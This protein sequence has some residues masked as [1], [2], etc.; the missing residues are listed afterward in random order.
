MRRMRILAFMLAL[1]LALPYGLMGAGGSVNVA[2]A[3]GSRFYY[4]Q[5]GEDAK[6]F[7]DAMYEMYAQGIFK[8]GTQ[9]YDLVE[10]GHITSEQLAVYEGRQDELLRLFGAARDAFY[11]DYPDI[12]YVDFS[13]LSITVSTSGESE[14]EDD[15]AV[16]KVSLG[17]GRSDTY[18]VQGF[19]DEQQVEHAIKEQA[20][21]IDEIVQ[22]A[23]NQASSVRDQ[24]I[25]VHNAI[26]DHTEYRL[27]T[28]CDAGNAGHVRTSYGALVRG[29]SLCEGYARAVKT[30]LDAMGINSVLVQG[31]YRAPDG[32]D[33][34][35]MWNYVQIDG[36]WYGLDAT[37]SDGM[38]GTVDS[39]KYLLA[40]RAVMGE[41]HKPDG[42]MSGSGFRFTYPELAEADKD[43]GD[44]G[45]DPDEG[46]TDSS[47]YKTLFDK[48]G[49]LVQYRD[50]TETEGDV[51]VFKVSYKG[52][53]Y[54]EAVDTEGVYILSRF[55]QYQPGTGDYEVGNWGYSDPK[56][57]AMPQLADA[58]V[59]ANGNSR[60]IEFAITR[61]AP[62]GPLYGDN[63][64]AED[65]EKNWKFQGTEE[66]FIVST[67]KLDNLKGTFI[68]SPFAKKVT[69]SNTGYLS[70]GKKYHITAVFNE[71]LVLID[72]ESVGC[73]MSVKDGWTA[74]E[75][76]KIENFKWD[77][78]R[79][80]EFDFTPSDQLADNY[81]YYTFQVTGLQGIGSLK[82][83]D[84]FQYE[85]KKKISICAYRSQG[86]YLNLGAKP[87]LLEPTDIFCGDWVN[88]NGERL[89]DVKN[90]VLT[91]SKPELVVETPD[92]GQNK[93]M[94]DMIEDRL[95]E[96]YTVEKSATYNLRLMTC[97]QNIIQTGQSV[98]LHIGFPEGYGPEQAGVCYKAYHFIKKDGKI[99]DVEELDCIVTDKGLM[100]TCYSF[101]PFAVVALK[102]DGE[103][104]T[105]GQKLLVMNSSG[106][107]VEIQG[108]KNARIC[109]LTEKGQT[110][111]IVI[112]AKD[113][114]KI[115]GLYL[116]GESRQ[117]TDS[118]SMKYT[119]RYED[120]TGE[121]NILDVVFA[122]DKQHQETEPPAQDKPGTGVQENHTPSQNENSSGQSG[123]SGNGN[124]GS[125]ADADGQ[126][127]GS[128]TDNTAARPQEPTN[129]AVKDQTTT[130]PSVSVT[131]PVV[132]TV[133]N[134]PMEQQVTA[135][136]PTAPVEQQVSVS[137]LAAPADQSVPA[138]APTTP[139]EQ[140]VS[141]A[142]QGASSAVSLTG[143]NTTGDISN[144][145]SIVANPAEQGNDMAQAITPDTED[146]LKRIV[147]SAGEDSMELV[148]LPADGAD[149][150]GEKAGLTRVLLIVLGCTVVI[151]MIVVAVVGFVQMRRDRYESLTH[152]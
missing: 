97:N 48:E 129:D 53:G 148:V 111:T 91:A 15:S 17:T 136:M 7:Y 28:N 76:S 115:S 45:E 69:P 149:T 106:G 31:N 36:K 60:Y 24:V 8:T 65:L 142:A 99:V 89:K 49:F 134:A 130:T 62:E 16:Y 3:N 32:S 127:T 67:G 145:G 128:N 126:T 34:L 123:N 108:D 94:Q 93:E 101:S 139:M 66:D 137:V 10:K 109:E 23:K 83:P 35:H 57:F 121:G 40:D 144:D 43:S 90:I 92:A 51:G 1:L 68:P 47:G 50:G 113:G 19:T 96:G 87:Q 133:P 120:L 107:D 72:G 5:L 132:P 59:L 56:P 131:A 146:G 64:T 138:A 143:T 112:K 9:A 110:R 151:A 37:A 61:K 141:A 103:P 95:S 152:H 150:N 22:G 42:V 122:E 6:K 77:N 140:Q 54:Q 12:F 102:G 85:A 33:N 13:S 39:G 70:C 135:L 117:V 29:Q 119:V 46:N 114:Y 73:K 74:E 80:V 84:G 58:L 44:S 105:T 20:A 25:Y 147:L 124:A 38:K 125:G 11:A 26:I 100:V 75:H 116:N 55:Y 98:R 4:N 88:E 27:D 18:F 86:I 21:R 14:A 104:E 78:D 41:H 118:A 79:T 82:A 52:K 63:V 81:A 71:Q 2:Y 30:V